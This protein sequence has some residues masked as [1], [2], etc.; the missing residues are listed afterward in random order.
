VNYE[1]HTFL[2]DFLSVTLRGPRVIPACL[3]SFSEYDSGQA[4]MTAYQG[5]FPNK[6]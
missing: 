5:S 1:R 3:E 6:I 2:T 4:G